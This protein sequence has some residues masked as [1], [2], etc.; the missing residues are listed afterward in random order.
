VLVESDGYEIRG[1]LDA[2]QG[3]LIGEEIPSNA[4]LTDLR[5]AESYVLDVENVEAALRLGCG[6][7]RGVVE[8]IV[9]SAFSVACYL[10]AVRL[11][12]HRLAL[13]LPVSNSRLNR[14]VR[15]TSAG[16]L[17]LDKSGYLSALL[18][19][20]GVGLGQ[21]GAATEAVSAARADLKSTPRREIVHGKDCVK[22]LT[23]QFRALGA[24]SLRD[25]GPLLW[26]S[27]KREKHNE[28]PALQEIVGYLARS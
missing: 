18:Q 1:L 26:S 28:Y 12:S 24:S 25:A 16:V 21:L 9:N 15:S 3:R 20:A 23:I 11:A 8:P 22:L 13:H 14:Y 17:T 6:I 4:W 10:A 5:D 7:E 2:D 27:F 19:S